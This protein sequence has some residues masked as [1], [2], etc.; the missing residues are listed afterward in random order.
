MEQSGWRRADGLTHAMDFSFSEE[1]ELLRNSLRSFL[2]DRYT[3]EQRRAASRSAS[4]W[5]PELWSALAEDIDIL[6]LSLPERTGGLGGDPVTTMVVMEELGRAL[7]IEPYLESNIICGGLLSRAGGEHADTVLRA[8][9]RGKQIV[10]FAWAEPGARYELST[11]ATRATREGGGWR[12][13]GAKAVVTAAPWAS[14]LL[15]TART[16]GAVTDRGGLSL[17]LID[18]D[19]AGVGT[20]D[21]PTVDGRRASDVVFENVHVSA[22]ALIGSE[23]A[24][25]DTLELATDEAIAA[26]SAEALGVLSR[27]HSDT[28]EY[29]RQRRQFGQPISSFQVLQHRMVDMYMEVEMARSATYLVTL[30]LQAARRERQ[31]AASAAKVTV[32]KACRFVGQNAVQLHGGMGMTDE[33]AVG[34]YFKRATVIEAEFGTVDFHLAR[35]AALSRSAA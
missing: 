35:H 26:S 27:L 30:N 29:A 6:G 14:K 22:Q 19:T 13:N 15:V 8:M 4:G 20:S 16:G 21:Y 25:I 5:R 34:H 31:L 2:N 1:Q 9:G 28:V 32:S 17:F 33:L 10:A 3:F 23:G 7:V 18:K 12:L 24:A 11:V